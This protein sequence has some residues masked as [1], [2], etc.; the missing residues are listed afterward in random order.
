MKIYDS[1]EDKTFEGER[2]LFKSS[3]KN[4]K[5]CS[6]IQGESALKFAYNIEANSCKFSSKYI[7]WHNKNLKIEKSHFLDGGRAS[8]WYSDGIVLE[9]SIVDAPKIF[10]DAKN[11]IINNSILNTDETLW[12]CK[13]IDI[14]DS[15][16]TGDY[17]L[18]HSNDIKLQ[19]FTLN[20]NYSFQHSKNMT[21]KNV[22]IKSKDP[23]W[24]SENI[25]V[26]DSIIEGEYLAWYSKNIKFVNCKII[27]T[28]P[29]CYIENLVLENCE[30]IDTD[31][32]F[33][34]SSVNANIIGSIDSVKN[35]TSGYIKAK[36]IN[37]L[38]LDDENIQKDKLKIE[39]NII[40]KKYEV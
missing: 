16:F 18:F 2:P 12:D 22:D 7:F 33:E 6:F 30:M 31:L 15:K 35:P 29:F 34:Y 14:S 13:N 37:E 39:A 38:I 28:Q 8:I 40:G 5:N 4:L 3:F 11:I 24:N 19:N 27:G 17:L 1:I 21:L 26:Y 36:E 25:T 10:R 9:N 23:F 20:G 32:A